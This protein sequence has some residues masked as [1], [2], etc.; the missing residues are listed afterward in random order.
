[1]EWRIAHTE[2]Y[3]LPGAPICN[4]YTIDL[5]GPIF[6]SKKFLERIGNPIMI[7]RHREIHN[8]HIPSGA[9]VERSLKSNRRA[10]VVSVDIIRILPFVTAE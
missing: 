10:R 5:Y 9:Q 7:G 8:P 2:S 3:L 6:L 1:L 4:D